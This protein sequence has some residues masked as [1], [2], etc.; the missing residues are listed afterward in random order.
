MDSHTV[1]SAA[2]VS[3]H[4]PWYLLPHLDQNGSSYIQLAL[5][6]A[7]KFLDGSSSRLGE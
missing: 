7:A 3:V 5:M 2:P 6:T 4:P 1:P